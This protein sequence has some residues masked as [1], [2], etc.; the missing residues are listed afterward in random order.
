MLGRTIGAQAIGHGG[1]RELVSELDGP[2]PGGVREDQ[3]TAAA[4][5]RRTLNATRP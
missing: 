4:G 3:R 2:R 5:E 1:R